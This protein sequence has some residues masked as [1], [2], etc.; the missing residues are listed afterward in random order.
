MSFEAFLDVLGPEIEDPEEGIA[1]VATLIAFHGLSICR[2]VPPLFAIYPI[3][4]SRI[5]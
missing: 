3:S 4:K 1:N 5:C 2:V